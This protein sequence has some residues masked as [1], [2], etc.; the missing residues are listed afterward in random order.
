MFKKFLSNNRG[1]VA[2]NLSLMMIPL[3]LTA[4]SAYDYSIMRSM[5]AKA[6][7]S[8]D[9]AVLAAASTPDVEKSERKQIVEKLFQSNAELNGIK[10]V[11]DIKPATSVTDDEISSAVNFEV[12]TAF[13]S[14]VGFRNVNVNVEAAAAY[15]GEEKA[16]GE[17]CVFVERYKIFGSFRID[18]DCGF[19]VSGSAD[20]VF[21]V[22]GSFANYGTKTTT[23][24]GFKGTAAFNP[25][26]ERQP[27]QSFGNPLSTSF[28]VGDASLCVDA[29]ASARVRISNGLKDTISPGIYCREWTLNGG[30]LNLEPGT[31]ILKKPIVMDSKHESIIRGNGV[32]LVFAEEARLQV[33][34]Q[35]SGNRLGIYITPPKSG[36]FKDIAIYQMPSAANNTNTIHGALNFSEGFEGIVY[37]PDMDFDVTGSFAFK[38]RADQVGVFVA[39]NF[40]HANG[41]AH[42]HTPKLYEGN[43]SSGGSGEDGY[44]YLKR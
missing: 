44:V 4:G 14:I 40:N 12:P 37:M 27:K 43:S 41:A 28:E 32:T 42:F 26:Q 7:A 31:Y 2:V 20:D 6:Q 34:S 9:S 13:M 16:P 29:F 18:G 8:I 3:A 24:G 10:N 15:K 19:H 35:Y 11:D 30:V 1:G 36:D 22:V 25:V 17:S 21:D 23:H 5:Q 33:H 39:R 38:T